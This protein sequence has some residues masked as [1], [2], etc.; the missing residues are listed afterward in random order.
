MSS[1]IFY[2]MVK[3][4]CNCLYLLSN[5]KIKRKVIN[6]KKKTE[7]NWCIKKRDLI[8]V[9]TLYR[10]SYHEYRTFHHCIVY[11]PECINK[12]GWLPLLTTIT[13]I[14]KTI[15]KILTWYQS[16]KLSSN[17]LPHIRFSSSYICYNQQPSF[18]YLQQSLLCCCLLSPIF[19]L[20]SS[21]FYG[22]SRTSILCCRCINTSVFF[23]PCGVNNHLWCVHSC[24]Y[25]HT[26]S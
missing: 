21:S 19:I 9:N 7:N 16:N 17:L 18:I 1:N 23:L 6:I 25:H 11:N 20:Y 24:C 14:Q 12:K 26:S 22:Q 3:L 10:N 4:K 8:Y 2:C 13:I 15:S 5:G